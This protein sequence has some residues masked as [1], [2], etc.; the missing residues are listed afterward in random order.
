LLLGTDG[1]T[2]GVL[3]LPP[4]S[5]APWELVLLVKAGLTPYQA[6]E[7][8]TRNP[9]IAL[10]A[11][12]STGTIAVGKRADLVLLSGNPLEDINHARALVGTMLGGRWLPREDLDARL[13]AAKV[14]EEFYRH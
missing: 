5:E 9:A 11:F 13:A 7:T 14:P 1:G 12:D 6:L 10:G 3:E 2:E 4:G 8:T